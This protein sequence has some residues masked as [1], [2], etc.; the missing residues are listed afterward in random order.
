MCGDVGLHTIA[1]F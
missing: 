1:G